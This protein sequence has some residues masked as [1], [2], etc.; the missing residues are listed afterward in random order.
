M[1]GCGRYP[2][3][4]SYND[5]RQFIRLWK[6]LPPAVFLKEC[7]RSEKNILSRAPKVVGEGFDA[8]DR[9]EVLSN[10]KIEV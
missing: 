3:Y 7:N 1:K 2:R 10:K 9:I 6:S 5:I 4:T 8:G